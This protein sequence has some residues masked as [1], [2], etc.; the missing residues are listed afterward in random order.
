M[1]YAIFDQS[2]AFSRFEEIDPAELPP[3]PEADDGLP[4]AVPT[5]EEPMITPGQ[6]LSYDRSG[7]VVLTVEAP[8]P[9]VLP[10]WRIR[11]VLRRRGLLESVEALIAQLPEPSRIV[12]EEQ[13]NSSSFERGHPLI[14][15]IGAALGLSSADLDAI[16]IEA[17]ALR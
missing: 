15:Q 3:I 16:F 17:A 11:T 6:V 1:H 12:A 8:V 2:G 7:W 10:S 5:G 4:R 9:T 14:G 13:M